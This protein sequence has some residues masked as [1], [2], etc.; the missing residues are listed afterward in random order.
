MRFSFD[1][2]LLGKGLRPEDIVTYAEIDSLKLGGQVNISEA[3]II[4][5]FRSDFATMRRSLKRL[6]K[7]GMIS[8]EEDQN[9][10]KIK[11]TEGPDRNE[12]DDLKERIESKKQEQDL[13]KQKDQEYDE[14]FAKAKEV[15]E[16]FNKIFNKRLRLSKHGSRADMI[17]ARF[18]GTIDDH[19]VELSDFEKIMLNMKWHWLDRPVQLKMEPKMAPY[20]RP[21]TLFAAKH[22]EDYWYKERPDEITK[23]AKEEQEKEKLENKELDDTHGW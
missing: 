8:F 14:M 10:F 4:G 3:M 15:I 18:K 2:E 1:D 16:M 13:Q 17:I 11:F 20:L 9:S 7:S 6:S 23:K 21:E 22:F 5:A 12:M 19:R